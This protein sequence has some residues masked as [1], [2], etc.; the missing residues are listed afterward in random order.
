VAT[1][2]LQVDGGA[3]PVG[4]RLYTP[5]G[6]PATT[7]GLVYFHGGGFAIGNLETHDGHCRRLAAYSGC[8]VLAIDYRLAPEN[9]FPASHDDCLEATKW[10]IDHAS[11]IGF[12]P[13]RVGVG[14]CSAGGNLA[15]SIAIDLKADPAR[16]LAFQMLLYPYICPETETESRKR[17]DGPLLTKAAIDWFVK[18]LA[19]EGHPQIDRVILGSKVDVSATPAAYVVTAGYD[20]LQDEG[21]DYARRLEAAGVPVRHVHY[22]DMLHDF[23]IM[24]DVSPAVEVAAREAA[25]AMKAA[26]NA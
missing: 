3:G 11:E 12:D 1:R 7:P 23:Y 13:A 22:P 2:D 15:A 4:A 25:E 14:G 24:G 6:A 5:A 19:A 18:C 26:L 17:M 21:C 16:R 10:A 9:P 20:P 8:R